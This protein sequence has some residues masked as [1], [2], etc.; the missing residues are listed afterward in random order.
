MEEVVVSFRRVLGNQTCPF[1]RIEKEEPTNDTWN[2]I[3]NVLRTC[4]YMCNKVVLI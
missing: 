2:F 3:Q 4:V 1:I